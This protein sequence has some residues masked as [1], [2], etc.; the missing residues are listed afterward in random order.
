MGKAKP[1]PAPYRDDPDAVSL[2]TTPDDYEYDDAPDAGLPPSYADS[3]GPSSVAD[4]APVI[5]HITPTS[6]RTDHSRWV[7]LKAGKPCV[8]E[9]Q[10]M[11]DPRL[12]TDPVALEAAVRELASEAPYPLVYLLGTH[13]ETTKRGD[14][15]ETKDVTDFRIVID[16]QHHIR[17]ANLSIRTVGNGEKTYR[18]SITKC[19]ATGHKQDIEIGGREPVLREWCHRYCASPRMLR[20]FRLRRVV[21][22]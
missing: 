17:T 7:S 18:G 12:D 11:S 20:V 14:K 2:H 5:H 8:P 21:C 19:R 1:T 15:T 9:T 10:T 3:Q 22:V 13:R 16:L 4:T 6:R